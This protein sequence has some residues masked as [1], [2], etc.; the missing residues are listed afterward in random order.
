MDENAPKRN[1]QPCQYPKPSTSSIDGPPAATLSCHGPPGHRVTSLPQTHFRA[2]LCCPQRHRS[3]GRPVRLA[4]SARMEEAASGVVAGQGREVGLA[5]SES[6]LLVM[7]YGG[8]SDRTTD[9]SS[10]HCRWLSGSCSSGQQGRCSLSSQTAMRVSRVIGVTG[11]GSSSRFGGQSSTS[12]NRFIIS[13]TIPVSR[14]GSSPRNLRSGVGR[15]C[16]SIGHWRTS[17]PS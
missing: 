17:D 15:M 4:S 13:S 12:L 9:R 8:Y 16:C 2:Q 11:R 5:L 3:E 10:R 14:L 1:F 6:V 7:I